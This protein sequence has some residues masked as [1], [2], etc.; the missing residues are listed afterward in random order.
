MMNF[1]KQYVENFFGNVGSGQIIKNFQVKYVNNF[2]NMIIIGFARE[3]LGIL[4][5]T[6]SLI[7]R[8]EGEKIRFQ[9][10]GVSG[11]IKLC[12]KKSKKYLEKWLIKYEKNKQ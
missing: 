1:I 10:L 11:T 4:L 9:T 7:N 3:N 6:L 8:Y 2:T 12:E 5:S